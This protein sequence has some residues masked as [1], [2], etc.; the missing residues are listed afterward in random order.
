V[1]HNEINTILKKIIVV[2]SKIKLFFMQNWYT[3]RLECFLALQPSR[4]SLGSDFSSL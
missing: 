4:M 1:K 3:M 2:V